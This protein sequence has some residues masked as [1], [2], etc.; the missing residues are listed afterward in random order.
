MS[1]RNRFNAF[2]VNRLGHQSPGLWRRPTHPFRRTERIKRA[3]AMVAF[4]EAA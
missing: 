2:E 1:K 4:G 3:G